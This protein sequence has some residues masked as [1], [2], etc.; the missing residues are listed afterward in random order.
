MK[1]WRTSLILTSREKTDRTALIA[2]GSNSFGFGAD[3]RMSATCFGDEATR[4]SL[5]FE[6]HQ[7]RQGRTFLFSFDV[8]EF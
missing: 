3:I 1:D 8:L 6:E 2:I 5:Q 7:R 4:R